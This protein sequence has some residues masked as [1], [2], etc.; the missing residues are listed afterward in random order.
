MK[1]EDYARRAVENYCEAERRYYRARNFK[2][3]VLFIVVLIYIV[4]EVVR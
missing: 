1:Y 4:S 3:S 2:R